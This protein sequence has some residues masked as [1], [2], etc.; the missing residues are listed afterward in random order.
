MYPKTLFFAQYKPGCPLTWKLA[1]MSSSLPAPLRCTLVPLTK[2]NPSSSMSA[3]L[4]SLALSRAVLTIEGL[5]PACALNEDT[6]RA[7]AGGSASSETISHLSL[8]PRGPATGGPG[9]RGRRCSACSL[10]SHHKPVPSHLSH[11]DFN[12]RDS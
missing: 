3:I 7:A 6:S 8:P 10:H 1:S 4:T 2:I 9:G 5:V 12:A 11:G